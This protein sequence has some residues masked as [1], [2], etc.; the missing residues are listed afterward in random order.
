MA[1]RG[2]APKWRSR[3]LSMRFR[4]RHVAGLPPTWVT[5][6]GALRCVRTCG[7]VGECMGK[8]L[9]PACVAACV[10]VCYGTARVG[11]PRTHH[12]PQVKSRNDPP[13]GWCVHHKMAR[14]A[15]TQ[16]GL[17]AAAWCVLL[18]ACA[19]QTSSSGES[20]D[21]S[22]T[23]SNNEHCVSPG[24]C[25]PPPL[26]SSARDRQ[27]CCWRV[28]S[29]E[30]LQTHAAGQTAVERLCRVTVRHTAPTAT[31]RCASIAAP[32]PGS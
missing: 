28:S 30:L 3:E 19:A 14:R 29:G 5:C 20:A 10:A 11:D 6:H 25:T 13:Q 17:H 7:P 21:T 32:Q 1:S 8:G 4:R 26:L 15:L 22:S 16:Q 23:D 27:V 2:V 18:A 24:Q 31:P 9:P 12:P